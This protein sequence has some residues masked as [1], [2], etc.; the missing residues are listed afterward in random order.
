MIL[1]DSCDSLILLR[2]LSVNF[3]VYVHRQSQIGQW[4]HILQSPVTSTHT[5]TVPLTIYLYQISILL[6]Y[7]IHTLSTLLWPAPKGGR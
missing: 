1:S 3:N 2:D 5:Y 7:T 4:T 6:I